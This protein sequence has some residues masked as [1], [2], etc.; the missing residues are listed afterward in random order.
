MAYTIDPYRTRALLFDVDGTLAE[1]EAEG[2]LPAFN[3][4]FDRLGVG[5]CWSVDDYGVLLRVTG[6]YERMQAYAQRRGETRWLTPDGLSILR[7]A[8]KLKNDLY[9][10]RLRRGLVVPRLGLAALNR[11]MQ[12]VGLCWAVVT[13]TSRDNWE[14]LW[15]A[16][17]SHSLPL[18]PV[19]A[20]C[21]EDVPAK[22]P[23]PEAYTL[24]LT[25]LG[26]S[27][28]ACLAVEDSPN[29]MAAAHAAGL[30]CLVVR[31]VF[32]KDADF[33]GALSVTEEHLG[34]QIADAPGE[35]LGEAG[36]Q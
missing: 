34:L 35:S 23:D 8:H 16:C 14:A 31:S 22:K 17:L 28:E 9:A 36:L 21:G 29:G 3:E 10:D 33:S 7:Q 18:P 11:Q 5:W 25:R 32:F 20:I 27:A 26:L 1:T 24:A 12:E 30:G 15:Q 19:F 13:T 4:A 2:H 6:G